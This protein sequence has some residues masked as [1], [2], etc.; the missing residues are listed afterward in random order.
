MESAVT[1]PGREEVNK[2]Q[3]HDCR[4]RTHII[5]PHFIHVSVYC[6]FSISLKTRGETQ[7][8]K[9]CELTGNK[10]TCSETRD[11]LFSEP[12]SEVTFAS[13]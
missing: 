13:N 5:S 10:E 11:T 2:H 8:N 7:R 3:Q 6:V 9:S 1:A 12:L 4:Q